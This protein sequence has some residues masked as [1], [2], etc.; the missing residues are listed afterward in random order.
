VVTP[1]SAIPMVEAPPHQTRS[2]VG[3]IGVTALMA[4]GLVAGTLAL[5][6]FANGSIKHVGSMLSG[7]LG[8]FFGPVL[9]LAL[10]ERMTSP[11]G[12]RKPIHAWLLNFRINMVFYLAAIL[13][14]MLVTTLTAELGRH[15]HLGLIDLRFAS[16]KGVAGL[17]GAILLSLLIGDFFYY[18]WHR[19]AHKP[20]LWQSHKLHHMDPHMDVLTNYR[21]SW[22]DTLSG[23]FIQSLPVVILFKLDPTE[24]VTAGGIL[25]VILGSY[26][27]FFHT[28]IRLQ[29]RKATA[30]I[31][32]PQW[33]RIHH[34]RLPEHRDKN[35]AAMFPIWDVL[36]GTYYHP[37]RGEFPPTGVDGEME[38]KSL[39]EATI[40][41]IREWRKMY[42][43]WRTRR[44]ELPNR[45]A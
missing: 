42:R 29:Y 37:A 43:S 40:F 33:H 14:G 13:T 16:G 11:A 28:N 39:R 41:P 18:W 25:G 19:F 21:D 27:Y 32:G 20:F 23:S 9:L 10:F 35:F 4:G 12:P 44:G 5:S 45:S 6:H 2:L 26:S 3:D 24:A 8:L 1:S 38:V 34:S 15:L 7:G 36:F 30:L 31:V 17:A 22:G